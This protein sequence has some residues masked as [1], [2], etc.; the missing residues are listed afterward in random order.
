V[1][2]DPFLGNNV[3]RGKRPLGGIVF[4]ARRPEIGQR[5]DEDEVRRAQKSHFFFLF[6]FRPNKSFA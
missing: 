3:Q 6:S 5:V 2:A 1:L 4:V